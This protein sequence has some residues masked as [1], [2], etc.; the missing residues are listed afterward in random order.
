MRMCFCVRVCVCFRECEG[1]YVGECVRM[2]LFTLTEGG[3]V[4]VCECRCMYV[5]MCVCV[6]AIDQVDRVLANGKGDLVSILGHVIP[7]TLKW[8]L[9]PPCLT[10]SNI[11]FA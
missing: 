4:W 9:I 7:K 5:F 1:A 2:C 11:R 3:N 8:Y 10:L 6:Y